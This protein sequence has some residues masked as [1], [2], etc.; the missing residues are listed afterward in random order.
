MEIE[1]GAKVV[2]KS[3]KLLGKVN[4]LIRDT[5]TGEV[6]KFVVHRKSPARALFFSPE[7]VLKATDTEVKLNISI[8]EPS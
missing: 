1:F 3:G 2:D 8:D 5:W 6:R 7:D 4:N